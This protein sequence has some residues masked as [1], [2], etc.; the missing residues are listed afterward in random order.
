MGAGRC[1]KA[2]GET[3]QPELLPTPTTV[4]LTNLEEIALRVPFVPMGLVNQYWTTRVDDD[5]GAADAAHTLDRGFRLVAEAEQMPKFRTAFMTSNSGESYVWLGYYSKASL[6]GAFKDD[7]A[8][9][10]NYWCFC[11]VEYNP[12]TRMATRIVCMYCECPGGW[13]DCS[14]CCG[15][16]QSQQSFQ[17]LTKNGGTIEHFKPVVSTQLEKLWTGAGDFDGDLQTPI[18]FME[19]ARVCCGADSLG[20]GTAPT[21]GSVEAEWMV[22]QG[23]CLEHL[24]STKF[25]TADCDVFT[26]MIKS[27]RRDAL[28]TENDRYQRDQARVA[29]RKARAKGSTRAA[30][31]ARK[32]GQICWDEF[33]GLSDEDEQDL[34][35]W[36]VDK[37]LVP[38]WEELDGVIHPSIIHRSKRTRAQEDETAMADADDE[39]DTTMPG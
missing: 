35:V 25:D 21:D 1:F 33:L 29:G 34:F 4:W 8:M 28:V 14:H 23:E 10:A 20:A 26:E 24:T 36:L 12:A 19:R 5:A 3:D 18:R 27:F 37:T 6:R 39:D 2:D 13:G 15:C 7:A 16:L 9:K 38:L 30:S 31:K 11:L 32:P 17:T 22:P